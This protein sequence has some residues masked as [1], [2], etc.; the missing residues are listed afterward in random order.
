MEEAL[1]MAMEGMIHPPWLQNPA[2]GKL[3]IISVYIM[4]KPCQSD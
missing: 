2:S 1:A 4:A 3:A